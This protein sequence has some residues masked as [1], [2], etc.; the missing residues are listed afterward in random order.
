[1]RTYLSVAI[2]LWLFYAESVRGQVPRA[3]QSLYGFVENKGQVVDQHNR[4]NPSVLYLYNGKGMHVQLRPTGFSY[5][6]VQVSTHYK[7]PDPE[8]RQPAD[9]IHPEDTTGYTF[10]T[11]RIDINFVHANASAVKTATGKSADYINYYSEQTGDSGITSVHH[12]T[13]VLYEH[14]YPGISIE[15]LLT[16]L[17]N[18]GGFK[19]NIIAD[20]G[21]DLSVFELDIRG[22]DEITL[23]AK[24]ELNLHTGLGDIL[25]R[26]PMS[27]QL[28]GSIKTPVE[29]RFRPTSQNT[30]GLEVAGYN[31]AHPLVID[32]VPAPWST[33]YGGE[34]S[35]ILYSTRVDVSGNVIAS[36]QTSSTTKIATTGAFQTSRSGSNDLFIVKFTATCSRQWATYFGGTGGDLPNYDNL[37]TDLNNNIYTCM[38]TT[39]T[40][41]ATTGAYQTAISGA[42]DA[43]LLKLNSSGVRQWSTYFGGSNH[44]S[45]YNVTTDSSSNVIFCGY[46]ESSTGIASSG[47]H[48]TTYGTNTDGYVAKFSTSGSRVWSTYLGG[49]SGDYAQA[50]VTGANNSLWVGGQTNSFSGIAT[51]GTHQ[52]SKSDNYDIFLNTFDSSGT[53]LWGT[54]FGVGVTYGNG[55]DYANSIALDYQGNCFIFGE[56]YTDSGMATTG[57]HQY[58]GAGN[59]DLVL[60]KF[61]TTGQRLWSTYLGC[62]AYD[63]ARSIAVDKQGNAIIA[64]YTTCTSG[65][66]TTGAHQT[67][68]GGSTQ[69]GMLVK[70]NGSGTR[71]WGTYF[72]TS[73]NDYIYD[74]TVDSANNIIVAGNSNGIGATSG[75][76]TAGAFQISMENF[77][78]AF[79]SYFTS[80]G[81]LPVELLY[82]TATRAGDAVECRWATAAEINNARFELEKSIN[83]KTWEK[84]GEVSGAGTTSVITTYSYTDYNFDAVPSATCYYYRLRQVDYD[85]GYSYSNIQTVCK[86]EEEWQFYPNPF[87]TTVQVHTTGESNQE[88]LIISDVMGKVVMQT[89][90]TATFKHTLDL[91]HL[92]AGIY[93]LSFKD[94]VIKLVKSSM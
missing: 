29:A 27:Y 12:Y 65:I 35:D 21:A 30:Y 23:T 54:Y 49:S 63:Y 38:A 72:G 82:F 91:S 48:Q 37:A 28:N 90:L 3:S 85:G 50:V 8:L 9:A 52:T 62:S 17:H 45:V 13:R 34:A 42:T 87:S 93:L 67:T 15:F 16:D 64:S 57:A 25:E 41:L 83:G 77:A 6:L 86:Q 81:V 89:T 56:S 88:K 53:R 94:K 76:A 24:G 51:S 74:V 10:T 18:R 55:N 20:P 59:S 58:Y 60:A 75:L 46:T 31:P 61:N 73:N 66:A 44:E 71:L 32:P 5:E 22:A 4:P 7:T 39:S 79:L 26:I 40:G 14:I 1:M 47:A 70:F 19:Y 33:Y 69:D 68:H 78:D 36:G 43:V 84:T 11:H 80:A 2:C 92:P